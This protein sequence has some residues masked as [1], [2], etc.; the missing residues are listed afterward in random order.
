MSV[1]PYT[2]NTDISGQPLLLLIA[3][4]EPTILLPEIPT[5]VRLLGFEIDRKSV[6]NKEVP[7]PIVFDFPVLHSLSGWGYEQ[8]NPREPE[9]V[10]IISPRTRKTEKTTTTIARRYIV[11]KMRQQRS[12]IKFRGLARGMSHHEVVGLLPSGV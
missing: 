4:P 7:R 12:D 6:A 5:H 8:R 9:A 1:A 11:K 2:Y 10:D 3:S